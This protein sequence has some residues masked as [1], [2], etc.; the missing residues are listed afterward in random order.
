MLDPNA[1]NALKRDMAKR[2]LTQM[3]D[4]ALGELLFTLRELLEHYGAREATDA[5]S[6]TILQRTVILQRM[7][8]LLEEAQQTET[9]TQEAPKVT[10]NRSGD[11][12][13]ASLPDETQEAPELVAASDIDETQEAPEVEVVTDI[14]DT[15]PQAPPDRPQ[16][17]HR[18]P[19]IA[20][21]KQFLA[22]LRAMQ[23]QRNS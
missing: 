11:P 13:V 14:D 15:Q 7:M 23:D 17:A 12:T 8:A 5:H 6:K 16:P 3:P 2:L 20:S 1:F 21:R 4:A 22:Q 19:A 18:P 9:E 10:D